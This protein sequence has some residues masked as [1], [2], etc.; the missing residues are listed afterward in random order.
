MHFFKKWAD[1]KHGLLSKVLL[2]IPAGALFAILIPYSLLVVD[3][4]PG[5]RVATTLSFVWPC[6]LHHRWGADRFGDGLCVVVHWLAVIR[7]RRHAGTGD[8]DPE[9]ADHATV[10]PL[11][12]P[13]GVRYDR[14]LPWLCHPGR[15]DFFGRA[16]GGLI[17][18]ALSLYQ[19]DRRKG[20][21]NALWP[22]VPGL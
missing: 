12:Q 3:A 15:F 22:E 19:E 17:C 18:N 2:L 6:Q 20:T 21:G 9:A 11:P 1:R 13:H 16:G 8:T 7:R 10:F 5:C 4:A 14:R